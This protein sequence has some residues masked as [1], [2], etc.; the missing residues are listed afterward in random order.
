MVNLSRA[1]AHDIHTIAPLFDAYHVFYGQESNLDAARSF[2]SARFTDQDSVI[3]LAFH[4]DMP[5]GFLQ[6]YKTFSSVSLLPYYI[7][8]DLFVKKEFRKQRV[9]EALLE[10]AKYH[11]RQMG[12][13]GLALETAI[14]NP[15]QKLYEKLNWKKNT[16]FFHYFWSNPD[17]V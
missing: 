15:A 17:L 3:F 10:K 12:Y 13:K 7:L 6:L 2:L 16:E 8:N 14:D 11:C 4:D 1:R 5:I 9:G